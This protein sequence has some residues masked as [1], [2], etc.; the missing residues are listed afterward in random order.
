MRFILLTL[1]CC[2]TALAE[3]RCQNMVEP[4]KTICQQNRITLRTLKDGVTC[5]TSD[6][7]KIVR[8]GIYGHRNC[9]DPDAQFTFIF[10][11]LSE[12]QKKC[13]EVAEQIQQVHLS[14][15][16]ALNINGTCVNTS[17]YGYSSAKAFAKEC[18]V[19]IRAYYIT[20]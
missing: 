7:H 8:L 11:K 14:D 6:I 3:M 13:R 10:N 15:T 19:Q 17:H 9:V 18:E 5:E 2:N 20:R 12:L 1:F 16:E 4:H